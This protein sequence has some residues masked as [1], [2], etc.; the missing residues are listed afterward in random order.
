MSD[1][2]AG[3]RVISRSVSKPDDKRQLLSN[4]A[5][6]YFVGCVQVTTIKNLSPDESIIPM[7]RGRLG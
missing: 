2:R 5:Q 1:G 6:N 3:D 4:F 7:L